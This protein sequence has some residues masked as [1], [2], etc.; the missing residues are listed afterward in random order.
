MKAPVRGFG[1]YR[2]IGHWDAEAKVFE[3]LNDTILEE[4]FILH[5]KRR[6]EDYPIVHVVVSTNSLNGEHH[7]YRSLSQVEIDRTIIYRL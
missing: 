7:T 2:I 6:I 1:D 4:E 3:P 5:D